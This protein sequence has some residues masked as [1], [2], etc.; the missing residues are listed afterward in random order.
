MADVIKAGISINS[1]LKKE[2][3]CPEGP[4][5]DFSFATLRAR[6]IS[7]EVKGFSSSIFCSSVK[8]KIPN[9]FV[10]RFKGNKMGMT[11]LQIFPY[12]ISQTLF[13]FITRNFLFY[14]I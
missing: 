10:E 6:M 3:L 1:N 13:N 7:S 12:L 8:K 14:F 11:Q 5:A 2:T 4:E 9:L